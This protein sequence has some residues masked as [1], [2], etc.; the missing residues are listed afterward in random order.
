MGEYGRKFVE[1]KFDIK[2]LSI[3]LEGFY[4]ELLVAIK[5]D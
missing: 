4:R 5:E 2:K 3:E 1:N